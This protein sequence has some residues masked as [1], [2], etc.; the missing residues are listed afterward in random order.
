M[1]TAILTVGILFSGKSAFAERV[2]RDDPSYVIIS[3]DDFRNNMFPKGHVYTSDDEAAITA[4]QYD[5]VRE[6][7]NNNQNVIITNSN[8][9]MSHL[10]KFMRV[11][12]S[13]GYDI[14]L[15]LCDAD[16]YDVIEKIID[17]GISCDNISVMYQQQLYYD[18]KH[19]LTGERRVLY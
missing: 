14:K 7:Y 1:A 15:K 3:R 2:V 9:R 11:L 13:I 5:K 12:D 10:R 17:S 8:L 4:R 19:K 6:C 16:Y 18:M